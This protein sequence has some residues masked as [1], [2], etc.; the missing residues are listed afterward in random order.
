MS[1]DEERAYDPTPGE[2]YPHR[3]G[4]RDTRFEF[5]GPRTVQLTG[6]RYPLAGRP[7]PDFVPFVEEMLQ[8]PVGPEHRR[9]PTPPREVP[10]PVEDD[11]FL[12]EL[13]A[14]LPDDRISRD[15]RD[16]LVHSHG[17]LSVDEVYRV[18]RG[19]APE[20]VVDLVVWPGDEDEVV[21]LVRLAHRHAVVLVPYGGGTNVTGALLCPP[22]ERRPV[23]SV[24]MR[25]MDRILEVDREN[26][27]AVVQAGI[28]GKELE[29]RLGER[30]LTSGHVPDS[31]ELSTLGG[32][33]ATR[34]SGMKKNRYGNIEEVVVEADLVTPTGTV[35]T[36]PAAPR[37]SIG[38]RPRDLLFGSEGSLGIVTR[39]VI[40]VH[41]LPEERRYAS[42]VFPS[43]DPGV[44]FLREVQGSGAR[45]ASLRLTNNLEFRLGRS[46]D[47]EGGRWDALV[48]RLKRL[49]LFRWKGFDPESVVACTAVM[50]GPAAE[51]RRQGKRLARMA[52]THRGVSGGAEGGRRGYQTTFAIAYIRDFLNQFGILGETLETSAPWDRI[53]PICSAAEEEL[54][55]GC[56]EHGVPG[57]PYLAYRVSQTYHTG[58][59][60]YFT[61]GFCGRGLER[62]VE[63]FQAT[64]RRVREAILDAGGSLSH[65]HGVGK[66]RRPFVR[67]VHSE[68]AVRALREMKR[69]L[70]PADVFAAGNNV[71]G[72]EEDAPAA[73]SGGGD[74]RNAEGAPGAAD[75]EPPARRDPRPDRSSGDP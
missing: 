61:M 8:V 7:L 49:Y 58:V 14:R 31:V 6:D 15:D 67:R 64:E 3:W 47:P 71:F 21:E 17:Q 40:R 33:I 62:P 72:L 12:R 41:P 57:R 53:G 42:W 19:E 51:V 5:R 50:E 16:R 54:R 55:L 10:P 28:T 45:P 18:T 36:R 46:L 32:W 60:I 65:H 27:R 20:R 30:G 69:A 68:G 37:S 9:E 74:V 25:R 35:A 52:K 1:R 44:R 4:Y 73:G 75:G 48:S 70:D 23:V 26:G 56:E 24:D 43:F 38:L 22:G 59:C 29:R 66:I 2:R 13:G 11:G 34:A 39:A 63:T